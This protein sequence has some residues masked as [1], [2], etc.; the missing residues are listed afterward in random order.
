[1]ALLALLLPDIPDTILVGLHTQPTNATVEINHLVEVY[2]DAVSHFGVTSALILG[3]LNAGCSYLSRTRYNK[4][5]LVTDARF[6]WL[7]NSTVDTTT[8]ASHCP[9][10]R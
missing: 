3:D 7:I 5:R 4:L 1:M 6:T 10:D 9:Y 8:S 2:E